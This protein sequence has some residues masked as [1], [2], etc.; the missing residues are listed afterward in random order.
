MLWRLKCYEKS[1]SNVIIITSIFTYIF[2]VRGEYI[3]IDLNSE[4]M[5]QK[6][7]VDFNT[8]DLSVKELLSMVN[9]GLINIAPEYQRQFRWDEERQSSLVESLFLGIPVPSLFMAT[10]VD[11]TWEVIDGV[12]R[13]STMICFAG[14][15][16]VRE[17]VNAKKV[18]PLK[19][20]GLSKLAN[21]NDK[22]FSDLPVGVQN[23]FKLTSIKVTTLSDKSDK[24]VRF[25]LFERLNKGGV[26]LTP[27]EIRS[28]VYRGGFNDFLKELSKDYNFKNCVHLSERQENDGTREELV[29]RFFAYLYDLDSFEHSVKDFLNNY[30]SKAD[31]GFNY[32][33]N[34]KLFRTV[35]KI[36]NDALPNGISKGRKNTPLNLFEAVSVGAALAYMNNGKINTAGMAEWLK[37]KELLKYI[38]GATN[39]KP[40]VIGRIEFC[41]KKFEGQKCLMK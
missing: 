27:Q 1:I 12:Q 25:D 39:S 35:F 6:M 9:D 16:S 17:K 3:M 22:R 4:L 19:L 15:D 21:F 28:C 13:L 20:K 32:S 41:R 11:G 26:N 10:N 5:E 34:D 38:T 31:K 37:D 14:D 23:K 29:L 7:K 36:L 18:E 2:T 24:D 30:M 40:R 33:E 8:Y